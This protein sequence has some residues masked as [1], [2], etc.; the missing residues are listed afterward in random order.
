[1]I[2]QWKA[3]SQYLVGNPFRSTTGSIGHQVLWKLQVVVVEN[4]KAVIAPIS[5]SVKPSHQIG[6]FRAV[7]SLA[8]KKSHVTG[9]I[10]VLPR[11]RSNAQIDIGKLHH[12]DLEWVD[13]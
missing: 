7:N 6:Q 1:M 9:W 2:P 10:R 5:H 13:V 4:F 8:W 12:P 11:T 3:A